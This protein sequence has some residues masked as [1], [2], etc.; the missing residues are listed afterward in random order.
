MLVYIW[1][2]INNNYDHFGTKDITYTY[3]K[4]A[5]I[6]IMRL[7]EDI[8]SAEKAYRMTQNIE[9][10]WSQGE[11]LENG[12]INYDYDPNITRIVPLHE[13][14]GEKLGLRSTSVNDIIEFEDGTKFIVK[15]VGF[16]RIDKINKIEE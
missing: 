11:M 14:N 7:R 12:K 6:R 9:G 15:Y 16:K 10:S 1:H 3:E 5:E 8:L 4:V 2:A 13:V